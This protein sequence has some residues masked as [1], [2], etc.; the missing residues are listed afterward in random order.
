MLARLL[1]FPLFFCFFCLVLAAAPAAWAQAAAPVPRLQ[2]ALSIGASTPVGDAASTLGLGPARVALGGGLSARL[3]PALALDLTQSATFGDDGSTGASTRYTTRLAMRLVW[4]QRSASPYLLAGLSGTS[5]DAFAVGGTLGLGLDWAVSRQFDVFQQL[6]FDV[7]FRA[8]P[9][10]SPVNAFGFVSAGVRIRIAPLDRPVRSL[11]LA[12]PDTVFTHQAAE[13]SAAANPEAA[14]PVEYTWLFDDGHTATG[15]VVA[16]AF[17]YTRPYTATVTAENRDGSF[18]ETRTLVVLPARPED[19]P[20]DS[21]GVRRASPRSVPAEIVQL[22]GR[23]TLHVGEVEN[24]RVRLAPGVTG[25]VHYTWDFGD[26]VGSVGNNV[27]HWYRAPGRYTVRA[28]A[29]N[30]AGADTAEAVVTVTAPPPPPPSAEPL[31]EAPASGFGWVVA[32]LPNRADA[33][34]RAETYR[35]AGHDTR[36]LAHEAP[37]RPVLYRVVVGHYRTEADAERA[38]ADVEARATGPVWLVP[39][40][41]GSAP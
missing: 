3:A 38:R 17:R 30:V 22:Y 23:R 13:F 20:E 37:R 34:T 18:S 39:F 2:A 24:F 21:V 26:G 27:A 16:R 15:A 28:V 25:V 8:E 35:S 14:Q 29:K 36:V 9:P 11:T 31:D 10:G 32:T 7:P 4:P 41:G 40:R 1:R 12:V 33:E 6:A 19:L 5:V